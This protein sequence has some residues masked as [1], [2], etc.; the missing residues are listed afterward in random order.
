MISLLKAQPC[1][2]MIFLLC[3]L[4]V[5]PVFSSDIDE[6]EDGNEW[7]VTQP[8]GEMK[9][10][11]IDTTESTWSN[12]SISED[13]LTV[14]FDMLG[15][16]YTMPISGGEAAPLVQGFDWNMQP[17]Y[18]P[19]G[20]A[21][22]FISD[23]DGASNLWIMDAGGGNPRQISTEQ[24][25][26]I[27]TPSWSPDGDYIAVTKGFMSSRSIPAGEIW[28]YHRSGGDG[29]MVT[30][31][32]YGPHTQ[33]NMTDPAFSPDG[34][35]LYYTN[36][37]TSGRIWEYG[38]NS[39]TELFNIMRHDLETGKSSSYIG[40]AGGAI[41]PTP[42]PDG[43]HM[44]YLKRE[45]TK[46]V[47][48]LK[49]LRSG[50]DRRLFAEMERDHQETFG[51]EGNFA[52]FDWT[53]D[54]QYIVYWTAGKFHKLKIDSLDVSVIPMH[55]KIEKQ[56]QQSPRYAVDVAP[57]TFD[58][59]MIRWAS[60]SP[61]KGSVVYQALGKL[62][63]RDVKSGRVKR[64][65]RQ[66]DHDEFY[67]SFSRDGKSIAYTTWSDKDLGSVKVVSASG[68]RGSTITT[69]PGIYVEPKFSPKSDNI[70]FRRLTGGYL[71]SPEWSMEPGIYIAD[72]KAKTMEKVLE[73]G[74][75]A[76]FAADDDRLYF[77]DYAP[78]SKY[79]ELEL[80]SVD[81]R[82]RDER[83]L[84]K[85]DKVTEY[86][87][88]PDGK[89]IGY[90]HQNN[91]FVAPFLSTGLQ[92]EL[93][94]D[95]SGLPVAQVSKRAG[96]YLNWSADSSSL[97]WSHGA[98][99]FSRELN[100]AFSFLAGAPDE[101]PE[102]VSE[103]LNLGFSQTSDKPSSTIALVGGQVVTMRDADNSQEIINNGVVVV[104]GNRI[105]AVGKMG[106][107]AI[108]AEAQQINVNGQTLTPGLIDG[109]AHGSQANEEIIPQQNWKNLSSLAF[110]VTTIHDPSNDSSEI[111]AASEMQRSGQIL[112]PRI[113]STGTIVYGANSP[114]AHA[115]IDSYEDAFFHLQRL[116]DMGAVSVKSYNQP[117]R[118]QRQQV[119]KAA[120]DLELM[121]VPE[122]G[123][124]L[125]QNMSMIADG[126]TTLE[127][128]LN[129]AAGYS[130][131]TQFWSQTEMAY[132]P[133][134]VVAYGGLEGEKYWYD[135]TN[136]WEN[137]RLTRYVPRY[138]VEPRSIRRATAPDDHYNHIKVAAYAKQLRD[139][140]V[141]VLI[142]AHG[143]REGL[144]AHWEM[145][146]LNQGGFTPWEALRAATHDPSVVLGM[147]DDLGSIEVGK[148][149]DIVIMDGEV[150]NNI[151]RSEMITHTMINGR[152]Y[153]VTDMS[154]VGS[155]KSKIDPLFFERLEINAMPAATAKAI[156]EKSARHH[157]VH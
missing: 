102:P 125:Y 33:K 100:Q 56:V 91:A 8:Q 50:V 38:K 114:T 148:L 129:I 26:L 115:R 76:H 63:L 36:D 110:G 70:V 89:W 111:F 85:G 95:A 112:G 90:T 45:D 65:T 40:G 71:L 74:F 138:I 123:G 117:R 57:D 42:S 55:I 82:G 80:Y 68:G 62:Y 104:Q 69:E 139:V 20:K 132:N 29:V 54:S 134:L 15:D 124:K 151:R 51:S 75:N 22:A 109:H 14:A 150:L 46:T 77:T 31:R 127:H 156:A 140:G 136:V 19:D 58:I 143:Q 92:Q 107:V 116:K 133:T 88:S 83:T 5:T 97:S 157:W 78:D 28:M 39:T 84:L 121:V 142:G 154:E 37:V 10:I 32:A 67:P 3:C 106:E 44:A 86:Q 49:D 96:E 11:S 105:V 48:Y 155:G 1:V 24:T 128:S 103:G 52:Y 9:T 72:R 81:L 153:D 6:E 30:E 87:L 61:T 130:D 98:T 2:L 53:P 64:L 152:L 66:N 146:M 147:R 144:A 41:V 25:A 23:R 113:F 119:L 93:D 21:I 27:H 135:R 141:R 126:H 145:W 17:A 122:G 43:K 4:L 108:P 99:I 7:D 120:R 35:Y 79:T 94:M 101:L 16:I 47:L 73:D 60:M 12:L 118:E 149:A 34:K 137:P 131:L 18:S 59:K 13:G